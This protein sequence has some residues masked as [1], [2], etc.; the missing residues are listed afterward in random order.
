MRSLI[1]P[2]VVLC[3]LLSACASPKD[4]VVF[5]TH[6]SLGVDV[7]NAPP[8]ASFGYGRVEGYF[9]HRFEDGNVPP[10]AGSFS[11]NGGIFDRK[12]QQVYATGPAALIVTNDAAS[13]PGA[14]RSYSGDH[15]PMFFATSTTLGFRVVFGEAMNSMTLGYK[16]KEASIIPLVATSTAAGT[17]AV[18]FP[19]VIASVGGD[20]AAGQPNSTTFAVS[21]YF[22]T[23]VAAENVAGY[24]S[25]RRQQAPGRR[26][27]RAIP[28]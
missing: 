9:G 7:E 14:E 6:T 19:S 18:T 21:Q 26:C 27:H 25:V 1:A 16:R 3:L 4:T 28:W 22:A 8:S 13:S 12:V 10:V 17:N 15:K 20:V 24:D 23:G 2:T 11:T 5:V